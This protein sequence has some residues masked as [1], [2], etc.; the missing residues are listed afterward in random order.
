[1]GDECRSPAHHSH[2]QSTLLRVGLLGKLQPHVNS[3]GWMVPYWTLPPVS[4]RFGENTWDSPT[5]PNR[6]CYV[7]QCNSTHRV[8]YRY[9]PRAS[10]TDI[11]V[12]G[13]LNSKAKLPTVLS[14]EQPWLTA[15]FNV[16]SNSQAV[17][18]H[19]YMASGG[20]MR[21]FHADVGFHRRA[22]IWMPYGTASELW[23][24]ARNHSFAPHRRRWIGVFV[25]NCKSA[26]RVSIIRTLQRAGL[27]VQ[28]HGKCMHN[29]SSDGPAA[30]RREQGGGTYKSSAETLG[31][32][33]ECYRYRLMVA[34]ENTVCEDYITE[35]LFNAARCGAIPIVRSVDG[36]PAYSELLGPFPRI[37]VGTMGA[38]EAVA[39]VQQVM[40][41]DSMYKEMWRTWFTSSFDAPA[42]DPPNYHCQWYRVRREG[43]AAVRPACRSPPWPLREALASTAK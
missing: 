9:M 7:G 10:D 5:W 17:P 1:M 22:A 16:E 36:V 28:S 23:R 15:H 25:S 12:F 37:D 13:V 26:A 31:G 6:Q 30:R 27:P 29:V 33:G 14:R 41:N 3:L 19:D 18:G 21:T 38:E 43:R 40:H 20:I 35:K 11:A 4:W 39:L 8:V 2:E 34:V 42:H 24:V 32:L